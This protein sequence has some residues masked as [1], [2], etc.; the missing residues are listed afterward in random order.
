MFRLQAEKNKLTLLE[1]EAVTSGS[2]NVYTVRFDFSAEWDGLTKTAVFKAAGCEQVS[3]LLDDRS[4]CVIPWEA[5]SSPGRQLAAGV[6]GTRGGDIVLPTVWANL[7]TI[8]EGAKPGP[9][10]CPPTPDLWEQELD[11]KGDTLAY[12]GDGQLGLYSGDKLLSFVPVEGGGVSDHRL[13]SHREDAEQHPI[14]AIC[15][16]EEITNLELLKI[17]NGG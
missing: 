7:G 3:V 2:V 10:S 4:Q 11:R 12:T 17:W 8:L 13:L 14:E 6:C 9:G 1:R 5:L 16:L 15:G